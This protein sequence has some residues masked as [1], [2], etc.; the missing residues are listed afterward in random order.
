MNKAVLDIHP[1]GIPSYPL[2]IGDGLLETIHSYIKDE[3]TGIAL[4]TDLNVDGLYSKAVEEAVG[5]R[6]S[7]TKIVIPSGEK[8]KT[9]NIK[10]TVEDRMLSAGLNRYSLVLALGGGVVSD[11]AGFVAAT[12][13]RSISWMILP[14][15]LLSMVDASIGG[16]TGINAPSGKN[17]IGA[18]HHPEAIISDLSCLKTLPKAEMMNGVAEMAKAG[19][20]ADPSLFDALTSSSRDKKTGSLPFFQSVDEASNLIRQAASVKITIIEK[21][22]HEMGLRQVLNFGHN[23]GHAIEYASDFSI[24]HG[25]AVAA[26]MHLEC[27]TAEIAGV[28]DSSESR[29]IRD[30]LDSIGLTID[31]LKQ[32]KKEDIMQSLE[33]DKK[34]RA[35]SLRFVLPESLGK[36]SAGPDKNWSIPIERKIVDQVINGISL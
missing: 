36:M 34:N 29:A 27:R 19:V 17:L 6:H 30:G 22:P 1:D 8:S 15:T 28:L 31:V 25:F 20:I 11:L 12:Y 26:G 24:D 3:H 10:E 35:N 5:K 16:K 7:L 9:R 18:F 32:I 14:T 2:V 13:M 21:D 23:F 33:M 4:V